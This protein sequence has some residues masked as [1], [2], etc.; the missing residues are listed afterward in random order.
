MTKLI[1]GT[2]GERFYETGVDRGVLYLDGVSGVP[3]NGL[4]SVSEAPSGGAATPY[5]LDGIKYANS[6]SMEEYAA[7][8]EAYAYPDEFGLCDGT[9]YMA[10]GLFITQQRRKSFG[11]AYRTRVGND[12]DSTDHGYK[13]HIVYNAQAD[14]SAKSYTT[15]SDDPGAATFSWAISTRPIK[16][17][18]PSFGVKYGSHLVLDSRVIYPWAML[19]IENVLYGDAENEPRLPTPQEIL[20][21][22]VENALLQILDNG[23]GTWTATGP[24]Q[25]IVL[26][27]TT[28]AF[29]LDSSAYPLAEDPNDPGTFI[30][31][32]SRMVE[33]STDQGMYKVTSGVLPENLSDPGT[34]NTAPAGL[35]NAA[36][37]TTVVATSREGIFTVTAAGLREST[38]VSGLFMNEKMDIFTIN[39]PSAFVVDANSYTIS[40][41]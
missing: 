22:F 26:V 7:T 40:S 4:I 38:S 28:E 41:L 2:V 39:W 5:Y 21:I 20:T 24:D 15:T 1:W 10:N 27:S 23:D 34:Y 31:Q 17:S 32:D 14:P 8:L 35:F 29:V 11:L 30:I 36:P 37:T 16:F 12:I 19:A 25:A 33:D 13:L 3:W 18:D 9:E 6:S